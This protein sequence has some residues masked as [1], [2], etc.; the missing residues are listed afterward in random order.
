MTSIDGF[1][2][3]VT[4]GTYFYSSNTSRNVVCRINQN[5]IIL[6]DFIVI[7]TPTCLAITKYTESGKKQRLFVQTTGQLFVYEFDTPT[8]VVKIK[9]ISI[10]SSVLYPSMFH[11]TTENKLYFSNY[12]KGT[13]T[14]V[15]ASYVSTVVHQ[16]LRGISGMVLAANK[17]YISNYERNGVFFLDNTILRSYLTIPYPRGL[18]Y[19]NGNFYVCYGNGQQNGIGVNTYGTTFY[20]D[21][22]SDFLFKTN[23]INT[24]LFENNLYITLDGSNVI[25]KN[26]SAF[27][28]GN[29]KMATY[30][31][32]PTITQSVVAMNPLCVSNP[33]FQ[34]LI[35][36]RTVGSNPNNPITPITTLIGRT[37]GNQI[38]FN[39]GLGS[40]YESLKMRRKAET[41]KFRNSP[42]NPGITLTTKKLF[43]NIVKNGGAYHFSKA[44]MKQLL[45]ENNGTLPC[46]I[47]V[48]NGAPI[49]ITPPT[50]SGVHDSNFEGYYLNPYVAYY[51]SL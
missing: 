12:T 21:V 37:Q 9:M 26:K 13:I 47:G 51:P 35:Q 8:S 18:H 34:K 3:L 19:A 27:S 38:P 29:F 20:R 6:Y 28:V 48:N 23:P 1:Y 2:N 14:T 39:I 32:A 50:N 15:D 25:Y 17:I 10:D 5:G 41:L 43:A 24:M 16:D 44:R 40:D 36:L 7:D 4:D 46:V 22:F 49:V 11:H 30:Y 45:N 42:N 33:A 31:N